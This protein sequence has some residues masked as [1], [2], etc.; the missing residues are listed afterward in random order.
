LPVRAG[1]ARHDR[2]PEGA[3]VVVGP[4][5]AP[6]P[7]HRCARRRALAEA[8]LLLR[9]P[10]LG[11]RPALERDAARAD[12]RLRALPRAALAEPLALRAGRRAR[13]AVRGDRRARGP[14]VG[15]LR[16]DD[17]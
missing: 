15:L 6:P 4:A 5:P 12:P 7:L 13:G 17:A 2:H 3:P 10:G 16:L 9:A 8:G 14:A 11:L 1:A